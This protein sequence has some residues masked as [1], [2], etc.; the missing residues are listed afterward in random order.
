[1]AS[2][3]IRAIERRQ[4]RLAELKEETRECYERILQQYPLSEQE[5][6]DLEQ[7]WKHNLT[8]IAEYE[9]ATPEDY[10]DLFIYT[11]D[12]E[13]LDRYIDL[14]MSEAA[15]RAHFDLAN[16]LGLAMITIDEAGNI[17]G[18]MIEY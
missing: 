5:R 14:E 18:E 8:F 9:D 2:A 4:R 12:S 6:I 16:A 1:M 11:Y 7:D 3:R 17:N 10:R 13:P 15:W